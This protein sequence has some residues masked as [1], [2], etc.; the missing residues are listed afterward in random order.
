MQG[1]A[2][3]KRKTV[4]SSLAIVSAAE[5]PK[6]IKKN[7]SNDYVDF[8]HEFSTKKTEHTKIETAI[9]KCP[10]HQNDALKKIHQYLTCDKKDL[11]KPIVLVGPSGC[12]KTALLEY[13]AKRVHK[14]LV[15]FYGDEEETIETFLK[16]CGIE[17]IPRIYVFDAPDTYD[18]FDLSKH[19]ELILARRSI[20]VT[21]DLYDCAATF[22]TK[23]QVIRMNTLTSSQV[24]SILQDVYNQIPEQSL[25][26][27]AEA[28]KQDIRYAM[29][30]L[31]YAMQTSKAK[32]EHHKRIIT[33]QDL[34]Y[35]LFGT[36]HDVLNGKE[37]SGI[38][39]ADLFMF[40][41]MLQNNA[42]QWSK[43]VH[44]ALDAF[45]LYDEM[46]TTHE[47]SVDDINAYLDSTVKAFNTF[48]KEQQ[49]QMPTHISVK[50][51]LA[52]LTA[53]SNIHNEIETSDCISMHDKLNALRLFAPLKIT[54]GSDYYH[55]NQ[56][57]RNYRK[58]SPFE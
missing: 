27:V 3:L 22:R 38:Q 10:M 7:V 29:N 20:F 50:K 25:R 56:D 30:M 43:P 32:K 52:L 18:S 15:T 55:E 48:T 45:C 19:F 21:T 16:T 31:S 11:K 46:D 39:S 53:S 8:T 5:Q 28:C 33:E 24:V 44:K 1:N 41:M 40:A 14:D 49:L 13:V 36:T 58:H 9:V 57:V 26:Y 6:E 12:G 35:D 37:V 23:C 2:F 51:K 4:Q 17:R 34:R 42:H 47:F 54:K